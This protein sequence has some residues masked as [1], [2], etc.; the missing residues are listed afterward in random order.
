MCEIAKP[1]SQTSAP[2][3]R[4]ITTKLTTPAQP[5]SLTGPGWSRPSSVTPTPSNTSSPP[6]TSGQALTNAASNSAPQLPHVGKVIQPQPRTSL[7]GKKDHSGPAWGL[8]KGSTNVSAS[9][10]HSEFPT[11]AEVAQGA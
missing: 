10:L 3:P 8:V 7:P 11:A 9:D 4:L 5:S 6:T 2:H 1:I